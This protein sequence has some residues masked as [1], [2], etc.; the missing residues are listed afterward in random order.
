MFVTTR[1]LKSMVSM[2]NLPLSVSDAVALINQ[3]L[4]YAFPTIVVE[5][6][7]A[8][9]KVNQGKF[10]F[11]DLKDTD[12]S[13]GCFMMI[14]SLRIPLEDGMRIQVV[15]TP[16]LTAWGKFSLTVREIKPIGEG[17]IKRTVELL[18]IK[19]DR[20]GLFAVERKRSLP[21]MPEN[22]AVIS[23]TQAAGYADFIRIIGERWGGAHI[24][25]AH[26]QVQGASA[27][28]QIIRAIRYFNQQEQPCDVLA[29]VRGGGSAD[30]LAIFNDEALVREIASSRIP[31]IVGVGHE[32]DEYLADYVA[33][34]RAA[35]PSHAAQLITPDRNEIIRNCERAIKHALDVTDLRCQDAVDEVRQHLTMSIDRMRD[36][37]KLQNEKIQNQLRTLRAY[38]PSF[39]L[40]RGYALVRGNV[41]VGENIEIERASDIIK[42]EVKRVTKK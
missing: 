37:A 27:S 32:T 36:S 9:F 18:K 22:I 24:L 28:D 35:T 6:E 1:L 10:V 25:V 13:L 21:E 26:V 7:V 5:G 15:G 14:F 33:D 29:I 16:K 19:L 42:A 4:E 3:S 39:V 34:V 2:K 38:D 31:T 12:S 30:D 11:F 17:T 20:E 23:S 41:V 40:A 8:S